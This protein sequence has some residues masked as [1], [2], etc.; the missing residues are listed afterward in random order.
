MFA[1][2]FLYQLDGLRL[3]VAE[4][5]LQWGTTVYFLEPNLVIPKFL[6]S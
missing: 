1:L 5:F 4:I 2:I 6:F 3:K